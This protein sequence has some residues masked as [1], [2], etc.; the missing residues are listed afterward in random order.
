LQAIA[1]LAAK[2]S[3]MPPKAEM[4]LYN[5]RA[6]ARVGKELGLRLVVLHG[7]RAEGRAEEGSDIDVAVLADG[8]VSAARRL[9]IY[10]RLGDL[11]RGAPLDISLLNGAQPNFLAMVADTG[12]PL[13]EAAP[14]EFLRFR[15]LAGRVFADAHKWQEAQWEHLAESGESQVASRE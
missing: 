9:R 7:S 11:I 10:R 15:S 3:A 6:L 2:R 5:R 12:R 14:G 1:G 4:V 8:A 13:Y